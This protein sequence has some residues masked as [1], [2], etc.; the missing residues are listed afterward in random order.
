MVRVT[1]SLLSAFLLIGCSGVANDRTG[2]SA[3][4]T[5]A[6][7]EVDVPSNAI[8]QPIRECSIDTLYFSGTAIADREDWYGSH[9][10]AM[11]EH[12]LCH[13]DGA[14]D[15]ATET[16]R[17]TWLPSFHHSIVVRVDRREN[18]YR[19]E[20]KQESGAGGYEAGHLAR[21]TAF[22]LSAADA[23]MFKHLLAAAAFWTLPSIPPPSNDVGGDGAQWVVEGQRGTRYHVVDR[24]SPHDSADAHYR[25][26][27]EWLLAKSGLVPANL[28]REY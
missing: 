4:P 14:L 9:L 8:G 19:F 6:P 27:A 17:L 5:Q 2:N 28:V 1:R 3:E 15:A 12:P 7:S 24:W 10:R 18:G 13:R 25:R 21:D 20:A 26:L 16:Y 22:A 23:E 11:A